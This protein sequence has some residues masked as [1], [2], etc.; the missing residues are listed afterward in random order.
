MF[1]EQLWRKPS[2]PATHRRLQSFQFKTRTRFADQLLSYEKENRVTKPKVWRLM[3]R[4]QE[5]NENGPSIEP[6][7]DYDGPPVFDNDDDATMSIARR[8][9]RKGGSVVNLNNSDV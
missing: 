7:T 3:G 6:S 1:A 9:P 2:D 5:F 8:P 4:I